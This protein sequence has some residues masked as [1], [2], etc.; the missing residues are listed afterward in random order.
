MP[1]KNADA[2]RENQR[3][4]IARPYVKKLCLGYARKWRRANPEWVRAASHRAIEKGRDSLTARAGYLVS[5][6]KTRK[7]CG[8]TITRAWVLARIEQGC[9]LTG[10][11]FN[12]TTHRRH[13]LSPSIDR[14]D[15]KGDYTPEN[16]RV[17]VLALNVG[18]SDW[19]L[20]TV[21]SIWRIALERAK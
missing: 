5:R 7:P 20:D 6:A 16:C 21:A 9:A 17:I 1:Y 12:V 11:P 15:C 3:R 10:L 18:I 19:G 4:Y 13:P 8:L 14:I 2:R